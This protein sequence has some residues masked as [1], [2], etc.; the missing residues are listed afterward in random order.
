MYQ[1]KTCSHSPI[2][3]FMTLKRWA[4]QLTL[5]DRVKH[6]RC[7]VYGQSDWNLHFNDKLNI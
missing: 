6:I 7:I 5:T 3:E 2:L 4:H 1:V